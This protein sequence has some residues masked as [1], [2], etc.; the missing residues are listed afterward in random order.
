MTLG[1]GPVLS[2]QSSDDG[3]PERER[4]ARTRLG[5]AQHIPTR[6]RIG[7]RAVLHVGRRLDALGSQP[8]HDGARQ[9]ELG[10]RSRR[11]RGGRR[12]IKSEFQGGLTRLRLG[13]GTAGLPIAMVLW[14][15][16][17]ARGRTGIRGH[18]CSLVVVA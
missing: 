15:A 11:D 1:R 13:A 2:C 8:C 5:A 9:A 6:E 17:S 10:E 16:A 14:F 12:F 7:D 3:K 18:W 4:L